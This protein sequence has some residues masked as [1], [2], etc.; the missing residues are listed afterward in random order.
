LLTT[1]KEAT[2]AEGAKLMKKKLESQLIAETDPMTLNIFK[3]VRGGE[4]LI[5]TILV[6][7]NFSLRAD[8]VSR[9]DSF[10]NG[11]STN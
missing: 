8:V 10:L 3:L 2:V 6:V 9:I 5:L 11:E 4:T 7:R 1:I